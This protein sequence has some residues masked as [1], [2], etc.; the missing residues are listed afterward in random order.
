M[1]EPLPEG[2]QV[3]STRQ[4]EGFFWAQGRHR[5]MLA[6]ISRIFCYSRVHSG[7]APG[8]SRH[9]HP[10]DDTEGAPP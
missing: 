4:V 10:G 1:P 9:Q 3:G 7:V 2:D 6:E 5:F 8:H